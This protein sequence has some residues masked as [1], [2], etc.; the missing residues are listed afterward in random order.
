MQLFI[1]KGECFKDHEVI[2]SPSLLEI[3]KENEKAWPSHA[4]F[5]LQRGVF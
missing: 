4:A 5:Y 1:C 2:L 3:L